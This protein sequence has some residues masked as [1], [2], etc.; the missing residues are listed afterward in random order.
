[1]MNVKELQSRLQSSCVARSNLAQQKERRKEYDD[2]NINTPLFTF[3]DKV[4]LHDEKVWRGRSAKLSSPWIGPYDIVD[5][6]Y[7]NLTSKLHRNRTLK[8]H[9]NRLKSLS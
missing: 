3:G 1:M 9:V 6:D 2:R 4:L 8:V 7:V 5:I